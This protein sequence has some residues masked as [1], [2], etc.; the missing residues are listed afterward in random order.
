MNSFKQNSKSSFPSVIP[1]VSE[2]EEKS[3]NSKSNIEKDFFKIYLTIKC[4]KC[5]GYGHVVVNYQ[6]LFKIAINDGVL[7]E[8]PKSDST[9]Y[10][11]VTSVIK[12]FTVTHT[13]PSPAL[14]PTPIS[15]AAAAKH[16]VC[17]RKSV[18]LQQLLQSQ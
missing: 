15:V 13:L 3:D 7:I 11:K 2:V 5:Q 9:I 6:S 16:S 12:K 1:T 18:Q 8:T 14:L 4:Y 17:I 10:P